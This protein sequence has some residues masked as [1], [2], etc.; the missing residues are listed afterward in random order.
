MISPMTMRAPPPDRRVEPATN[1]SASTH[2][3]M[4]AAEDAIRFQNAA[5]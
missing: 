3:G 4:A 1:G 5:K 2:I